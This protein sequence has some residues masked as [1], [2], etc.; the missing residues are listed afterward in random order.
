VKLIILS[1]LFLLCSCRLTS[2]DNEN[3]NV[4]TASCVISASP[5]YCIE[6]S[7]YAIRHAY[8]AKECVKGNG[9]WQEGASCPAQLKIF[10]CKEKATNPTRTTWYEESLSLDSAKM[11]ELKEACENQKY[12]WVEGEVSET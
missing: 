6:Y 2:V 12:L 3:W 4:T 1:A 8:Y 10:A 9:K 5:N 7:D 11:T